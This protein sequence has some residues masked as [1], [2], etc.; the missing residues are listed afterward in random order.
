M[1]SGWVKGKGRRGQKPRYAMREA[2]R[3]L[4]EK[5]IKRGLMLS[6][7][8]IEKLHAVSRGEVKRGAMAIVAA[9]RTC[10]EWTVPRPKQETE[11]TGNV[12][13][14]VTSPLPGAPGSIVKALPVATIQAIEANAG[15]A[16]KA[17]GGDDA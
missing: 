7:G 1:P 3:L 15:D 2:T 8:G 12:T 4:T 9:S 14:V 10:L 6:Q 5:Q 11:L 17:L 16:V 13:I